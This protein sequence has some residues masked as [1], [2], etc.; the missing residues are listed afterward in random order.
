[1][2]TTFACDYLAS[3]GC[4]AWGMKLGDAHRRGLTA[5]FWSNINPHGT[6]RLDKGLDLSGV[7]IP[8]QRAAVSERAEAAPPPAED[9]DHSSN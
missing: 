2:R 7:T 9:D 6:L 1:M 3:P 4:A 8:G 5:L